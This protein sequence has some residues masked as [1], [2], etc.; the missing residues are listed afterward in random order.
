LRK[1]DNLKLL[2]AIAVP[3]LGLLSDGYVYS[4]IFSLLVDMNYSSD[5]LVW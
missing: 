4:P 5:N 2:S 1:L 3:Q